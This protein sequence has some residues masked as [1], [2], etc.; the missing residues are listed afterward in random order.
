MR[1]AAKRVY[2]TLDPCF[3][4]IRLPAR[5]KPYGIQEKNCLNRY[6]VPK[7]LRTCSKN[8]AQGRTSEITLDLLGC[9]Q[10]SS[11]I[12]SIPPSDE[13]ESSPDVGSKSNIQVPMSQAPSC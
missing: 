2:A 12:N 9:E 6:V 11:Q 13:V 1:P 8:S 7:L 5:H 3:S 4:F 10:T